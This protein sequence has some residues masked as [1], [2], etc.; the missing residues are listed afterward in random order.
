[1]LIETQIPPVTP[2]VDHGALTGLGDDDHTQY[3]LANGTRNMT[4][5]YV[6]SGM[7]C[8]LYTSSGDAC[9]Y[10]DSGNI[11][12]YPMNHVEI[13]GNLEITGTEFS[14]GYDGLVIKQ[15]SS[16]GYAVVF[17]STDSTNFIFR[18]Q[19]TEEFAVK[20]DGIHITENC[21]I[22]TSGGDMGLWSDAGDIVFYPYNE[23]I[24]YYLYLPY[25]LTLD[26][27]GSMSIYDS[28]GDM[29]FDSPGGFYLDGMALQCTG[30]YLASDG[31]AGDTDLVDPSMG[32]MEFIDGLYVG[33]WQY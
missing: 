7:D 18:Y 10:A 15:D 27:A 3:L 4:E 30:G 29:C 12:F 11:I 19:G 9:L 20:S 25:G 13:S 5:L 2:I 8:Y 21:H 26:P 16:S 6:G 33:Q 32:D 28:V 1:M 23:T 22:L 24:A 14:M 17:D 31:T